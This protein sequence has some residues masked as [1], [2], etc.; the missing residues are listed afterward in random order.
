MKPSGLTESRPES[1]EQHPCNK[2]CFENPKENTHGSF[3]SSS[4][5]VSSMDMPFLNTFARFRSDQENYTRTR[6]NVNEQ[7]TGESILNQRETT[8]DFSDVCIVPQKYWD[9]L[10]EIACIVAKHAPAE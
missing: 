7:R 9:S 8:S 5:V 10:F 4:C 1:Q 3:D 6:A 2:L